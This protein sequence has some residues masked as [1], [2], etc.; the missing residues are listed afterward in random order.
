MTYCTLDDVQAEL[1]G[2]S[3][4]LTAAHERWL[5]RQ[6]FTVSDQLAKIAGGMGYDLEPWYK[7]V[8]IT[9]QP[10]IVNSYDKTLRLPEPLLEL[11]SA[12]VDGTTLTLDTDL[13]YE[14]L[15]R[16]PV[17]VLRIDPDVS[18]YWWPST[19]SDPY[20][21]IVLTGFW[22][23]RRRYDTEGFIQV[24]TVQNAAGI[25]ASA[26]SVTVADVDGTDQY[27]LTPRI[28]YGSLLRIED[29]LILV[30]GTDTTANTATTVRGVNGST[31]AAHAN[32]TAISVWNIEPE[33][34]EEA[35]RQ[36]ALM[37]AR[38]G[39]YTAQITEFGT[40]QYPVDLLTSARAALQ[41]IIYS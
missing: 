34:R 15:Y 29:E 18:T 39:A 12:T 4:K 32:G 22:G 21:T 14:P 30:T 17:R 19:S 11:D 6:L 38:R 20:N 24:D 26:T 3:T 10:T 40:V 16:Y 35:T 31:A 23:Y 13:Y 7:T 36:V 1:S 28:S 33:M 27:G 2:D 41:R 8:K 5:K 25:T 9:P 37:Y